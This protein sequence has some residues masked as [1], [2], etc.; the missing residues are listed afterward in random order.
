MGKIICIIGG[1]FLIIVVVLI[2]LRQR[3]KVVDR[4]AEQ[5]IKALGGKIERNP[6]IPGS[7]IRVVD[8]TGTQ[9]TDT[10][11]RELARLRNVEFLMLGNTQVTDAG[12]KEI[13]NLN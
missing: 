11:L 13:A 7:P 1:V 12:L 6:F 4:E 9:L 3:G 2:V 8:F 10:G 5:V